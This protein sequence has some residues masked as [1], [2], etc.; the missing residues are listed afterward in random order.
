MSV[1]TRYE[2]GAYRAAEDSLLVAPPAPRIGIGRG[3]IHCH[4][5][6]GRATS[7]LSA[8]FKREPR[9]LAR[10]G[11]WNFCADL[12]GDPFGAPLGD[13]AMDDADAELGLYTEP[14]SLVSLVCGSMGALTG[15]NWY[16]L[17]PLAVSAI[18]LIIPAL[19]LEDLH[20]NRGLDAAIEAPNAFGSEAAYLAAIAERSPIE[21]A[22]DFQDVPI[23]IYYSSDD[24]ICLPVI[25]EAFAEATNAELVSLG[26][27][28]HNA[29]TLDARDIVS[30]IRSNT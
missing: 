28:G 9:A 24:P 23:R 10:A 3:V 22:A 13:D 1:S 7:Y 30:F 17:N 12:A 14:D 6:T 18:A 20:D 2:N 19:D 11:F 5:Y 27:I 16:R 8:A 21:N 25:C 15:L 26:A 4:G 29:T